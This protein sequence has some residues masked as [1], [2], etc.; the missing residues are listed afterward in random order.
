[1]EF[2]LGRK[3]KK[4][5]EVRTQRI[6]S[7]PRFAGLGP[8]LPVG[9][10]VGVIVLTVCGLEYLRA[11]VLSVPEYNPSP[12]IQLDYSPGSEWVKDEGWL[13]RI[14]ASIK[15][16]EKNLKSEDLLRTV[17]Q[18]IVESGW[19]RSVEQVTRGMDG[20]I[21]AVCD[22]RR[23]VAMVL[24]N[25]GKYIP[26]DKDGVR[27]PEEYDRVESDSGWMRIIGVQTEPP[28]VGR[29]Y[30]ELHQDSDAIAAIRLAV[31]LFNQNDIADRISGIDVSNFNGRENRFK[32]HISLYAR[33]GRS[34]GWGSAI[35]REVEEPALADKLRNLALWLRTSSPQAHADL[36]VY[37]DGVLLP[38]GK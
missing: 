25:R 14:T 12:R 36:T 21:R 13:P 33:D 18:Q 16:P 28:A 9:A 6:A 10:V 29:S 32:T 23:P 38:M 31:L 35:G 20:T 5:R 34:A 3:L 26:I 19:V 22:Y 7:E 27:L 4:K 30:A 17:A 11:Q 15:L 8:L 2:S 24:T 37:R 1:L